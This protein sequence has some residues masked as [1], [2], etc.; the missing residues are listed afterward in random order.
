MRHLR[1]GLAC[2]F[3]LPL[4]LGRVWPLDGHLGVHVHMAHRVLGVVVGAV[5]LAL[6]VRLWVRP[7][8]R[9]LRWLGAA[10]GAGVLLQIGLGVMTVL[11]SR[12]IVTMTVHSTL[13]AALLAGVVSIFWLA[14]PLHFS[15]G[16]A[17]H[18]AAL[19]SRDALEVA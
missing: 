12:E 4:C 14:R 15:S 8:T 18:P 5:V 16:A 19:S 9:V 7:S 11:L 13:G 17:A 2:G 10:T 6:A 3:D 1:G